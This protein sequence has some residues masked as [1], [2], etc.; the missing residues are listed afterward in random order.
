MDVS[1]YTAK[2]D[3]MV[4][5][6]VFAIEEATSLREKETGGLKA[7]NSTCSKSKVV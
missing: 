6:Y 4:L 5:F 7:R 1:S 2:S 3:N